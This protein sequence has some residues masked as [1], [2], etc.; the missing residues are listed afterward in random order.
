MFVMTREK[1]EEDEVR[2][3]FI[4]NPRFDIDDVRKIKAVIRFKLKDAPIVESIDEGIEIHDIHT[5]MKFG[6]CIGISTIGG[7]LYH[8]VL[9]VAGK[10]TD[11]VYVLQPIYRDGKISLTIKRGYSIDKNMVNI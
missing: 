3:L 2:D 4:T 8:M 5:M 9:R 7:A 6:R 1:T 11:T 10:D